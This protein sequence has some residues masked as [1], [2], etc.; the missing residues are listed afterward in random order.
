MPELTHLG[1]RETVSALRRPGFE[2]AR[3]R[4]SHI[5][6]RWGSVGCVL[7][8]PR[9]VKARTFASIPPEAWDYRLGDRSALE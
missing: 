8:I 2:T 6:M 7:R 4:G 3:K 1:G 9:E 5:V